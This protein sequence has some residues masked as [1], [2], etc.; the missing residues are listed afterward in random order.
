VDDPKSPP[1][2][3]RDA[4]QIL[5]LACDRVEGRTRALAALGSPDPEFQKLALRSLTSN[6]TSLAQLREWLSLT[7][8]A[9]ESVL[10]FAAQTGGGL[11]KL[12]RD[13]K[14]D[15]LK[16]LLSSNDPETVA[17]AGYALAL[18]EDPE[19]LKPLLDYAIK[20]PSK[21]DSWDRMAY[22]AISQAGDDSQVALIER[23]YTRIHADSA[24]RYGSSEGV[25]DFYWTIRGMDGPNARKLRQKIRR[26]VG[27]PFLRGENPNMQGQL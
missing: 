22:Q 15:A 9:S 20:H 18:L 27:M 1:S 26:E 24:T 10:P 12:P 2:L 17:L 8:E 5:L 13:L 14:V 6:A 23:I 25:R 4:F 11:P 3:R 16:P 7:P 21:A 19:G